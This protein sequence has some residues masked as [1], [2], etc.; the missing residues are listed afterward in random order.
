MGLKSRGKRSLSIEGDANHANII[1]GEQNV[2][3]I[4]QSLPKGLPDVVRSQWLEALDRLRDQKQISSH[5]HS[6]VVA[7]VLKLPISSHLDRIRVETA[8]AQCGDLN[9]RLYWNRSESEIT[10]RVGRVH[11]I[12]TALRFNIDV[13]IVSLGVRFVLIPPGTAQDGSVNCSYFFIAETLLS[14]ADWTRIMGVGSEND[15]PQSM[16][17]PRLNLSLNSIQELL[18]CANEQISAS[19][20]WSI[21]SDE[22]WRF[23][24]AA[25]STIT[26]RPSS[27]T[28]KMNPPSPLGVYDLVGVAWQFCSAADQFVV[29]GGSWRTTFGTT[30]NSHGPELVTGTDFQSEDWGFRP[31]LR[32]ER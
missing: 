27:F 31:A 17:Q 6:A 5:D 10:N 21:P 9:S 4:A 7:H 2:I 25:S 11:Q 3:N 15:T 32:L 13:E 19:Q 18:Q 8:L 20:H 28:L 26:P 14:E 24:K 1:I 12:L 23:I 29:Q 30:F 22:N 16:S